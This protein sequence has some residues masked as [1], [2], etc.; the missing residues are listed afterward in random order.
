M[1]RGRVV[2]QPFEWVEVVVHTGH[3]PTHCGAVTTRTVRVPSGWICTASTMTPSRPNSTELL[4]DMLAP[5]LLL[6]A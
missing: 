3:T 6:D 5:L 2:T 4:W 1:S